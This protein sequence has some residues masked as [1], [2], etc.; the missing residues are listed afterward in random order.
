MCT[1]PDVIADTIA[2]E[3]DLEQLQGLLEDLA[4]NE[5]FISEGSL[6]PFGRYA[7]S[8]QITNLIDKMYDW[9]DWNQYKKKGREYRIIALGALMLSDTKEAFNAI[10]K[11][12]PLSHEKA[13]DVFSLLE[14]WK[15]LL[16]EGNVKASEYYAM[17]RERKE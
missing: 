8:E 10:K 14:N 3:L 2:K 13:R 16:G 7:S 17:I 6:L 1:E 11:V 9:D 15:D 12:K 4:Y 5:E